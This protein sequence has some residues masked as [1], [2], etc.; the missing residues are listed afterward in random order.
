MSLL[1]ETTVHTLGATPKSAH[2][3]LLLFC[4][5]FTCVVSYVTRGE[6]THTHT[7]Y[8]K[9][10]RM[11]AHTAAHHTTP[12]HAEAVVEARRAWLGQLSYEVSYADWTY[13]DP[14][15]FFFFFLC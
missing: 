3:A 7:L 1:M 2:A 10:H 11:H 9:M 4:P 5:I 6:C 8:S 12:H 14:V 13:A 15:R